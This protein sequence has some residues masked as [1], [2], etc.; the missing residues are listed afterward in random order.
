M[1]T[2]N[3]VIYEQLGD[4]SEAVLCHPSLGLG[5]F[6]FHRLI[7]ILSRYYTVITWDP[8]GIGENADKTPS[9]EAWVSDVNEFI[10]GVGRP[11]HLVGVSLGTWVMSRV[12]V[13]RP[14]DVATITLIGATTGF[15]NGPALV[16]ERRA[17][18]ARISMREFAEQ[19][20]ASTLMARVNP[21]LRDNLIRELA[22]VAPHQYLAAM[23]AI[24]V[25][26]NRGIYPQI[27]VPALVMVGTEDTRTP[28][29]AAD[30]VAQLIE[31]SRVEI[32]PQAG[33]LALLDRP[34]RTAEL[35]LEFM[36]KPRS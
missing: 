29:R 2:K 6:L 3:G 15:E 13:T 14:R 22:D 8:R 24:Y 23:E 35:L 18:L 1:R 26:S 31:T 25:V 34:V 5:R 9:L 33:H 16:A 19:Y 30:R 17:Q 20:A 11:V 27:K 36:R 7:P 12:A 10:D 32:I 28:P 21:E 4:H